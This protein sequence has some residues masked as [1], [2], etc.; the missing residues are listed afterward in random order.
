MLENC[1]WYA[2]NPTVRAIHKAGGVAIPA[3]AGY[4]RCGGQWVPARPIAGPE[5]YH[6]AMFVGA[7]PGRYLRRLDAR[8]MRE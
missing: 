6:R 7:M 1:V 5:V 2:V 8:H 4:I 3:P